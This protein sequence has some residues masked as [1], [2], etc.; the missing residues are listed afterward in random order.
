M[1]AYVIVEIQ[2][3]DPQLYADYRDRAPESIAQYGG[4]YLVRGGKSELL[5]G[6]SLPERFV[7]LEFPNVAQ[8]KAWWASEEYSAIKSIRYAAAESKM[9]VIEGVA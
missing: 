8:A 4:R 7:I 1:A 2:V 3:K 5:E 9:F 6:D